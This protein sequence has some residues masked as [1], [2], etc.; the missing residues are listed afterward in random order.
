MHACV[1]ARACLYLAM[2]GISSKAA[3][4]FSNS[5]QEMYANVIVATSML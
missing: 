2:Q 1:R 3:D 5:C 4:S